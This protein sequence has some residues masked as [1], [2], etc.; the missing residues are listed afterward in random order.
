MLMSLMP[1]LPLVLSRK[2]RV[3]GIL[4][5]IYLYDK[6]RFHGWRLWLE[7]IR[8][9][10]L[11]HHRCIGRV[12]VLNDDCAAKQLNRKY[13]T[14][15]F[16]YLPDPIPIV[17]RPCT[18]DL[19]SELGIAQ[20]GTVYLHFGSLDT[21][22]GTLEILRAIELMSEVEL[23]GKVF[24]FAGRI[25]ASM[26]EDFYRNYQIQKSRVKILVFD[27]F[28]TYEFLHNLC[29]ATDW[30][31]IPYTNPNQ[32]SGVI[33]YAGFWHKPVI[34][35]SSGLL[36]RLIRNYHLGLCLSSVKAAD[37]KNAVLIETP[38]S[39]KSTYAETH[40]VEDFIHTIQDE[41]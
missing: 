23:K 14:D 17:A 30:I 26:K 32:S 5:R 12:Y 15:R 38:I 28:C 6:E 25:A 7:Y 11:A 34:G 2:I 16:R 3:D 39:E 35:P 13:R 27:E 36:G 37:I 33:G 22:K 29:H 41:M 9:N 10:L 40:R 19:R 24:I 20:D 1:F 21:R 8:Y 18:T 4:Y 31:L